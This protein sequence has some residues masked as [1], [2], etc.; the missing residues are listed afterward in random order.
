MAV[1]SRFSPS[2]RGIWMFLA[3]QPSTNPGDLC[4]SKRTES[5]V[6]F[7]DARI[8]EKKLELLT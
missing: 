6:V 3:G 8:D 1:M 5:L 2:G 4:M 7:H